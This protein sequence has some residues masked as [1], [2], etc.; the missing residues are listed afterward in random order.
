MVH[1][2]GIEKKE[3]ELGLIAIIHNRDKAGWA[4]QIQP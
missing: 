2:K 4:K 3:N 1:A